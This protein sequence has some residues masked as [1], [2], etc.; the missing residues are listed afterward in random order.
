MLPAERI[1]VINWLGPGVGDAQRIASSA[2]AFFALLSEPSPNAEGV[3]LDVFGVVRG[4]R[5][6]RPAGRAE[7]LQSSDQKACRV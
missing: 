1:G 2:A 6:G 3:G 5:A 7:V 4:S